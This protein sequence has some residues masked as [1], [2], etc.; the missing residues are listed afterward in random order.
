MSSVWRVRLSE[1]AEQ[2]LRSIMLWTVENFGAHQAVA[3]AESETLTFG[4]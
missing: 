4:Q 2:D 3:Y 1:Q